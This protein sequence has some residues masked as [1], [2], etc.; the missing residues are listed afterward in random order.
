MQ[1]ARLL[2]TSLTVIGLSACSSMG[3]Q[4]IVDSISAGTVSGGSY[5][6]VSGMPDVKTDDLYFQEFS[7]HFKPALDARGYRPVS[8]GEKPD[9]TIALAYGLSDGRT[10]TQSYSTPVY[11]MVGGQ[12]L[13]ITETT[14]DNAGASNKTTRQIYVPVS[15]RIIGRETHVYSYTTYNAFVILEA[16]KITGEESSPLWKTTVQLR[17]EKSDLRPIIAILANAS[18]PY[19]GTNTGQAIMVKPTDRKK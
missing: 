6:L 5:T 2:I 9:I 3:N 18:A 4:I 10:N 15:S 8:Q 12:T 19:V 14:T 7:N 13:N 11:G 17:T 1:I 16:R